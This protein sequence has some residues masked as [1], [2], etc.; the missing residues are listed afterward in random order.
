MNSTPTKVNGKRL[1]RTVL[2]T[3]LLAIPAY[4][5]LL[6]VIFSNAA[7]RSQLL[8]F[9]PSD[10]ALSAA[11][12]WQDEPHTCGLLSLR[13]IYRA[14]NLNPELHELRLR[15]GVDR[16]TVFKMKSTE[17][18]LHADICRVLAQD[19]FK[20]ELLELDSTNSLTL[21]NEHMAKTWKALALIRRS[22]NGN[23]HW[24]VLQDSS[25]EQI[26]VVDSLFNE[27]Y[28]ANVNQFLEH[29]AVSVF[30]VTPMKTSTK[31]DIKDAHRLGVH[32]MKSSLER[33]KQLEAAKKI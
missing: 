2:I 19:G 9:S 31:Q 13:S 16:A 1:L 25:P 15:L 22:E 4:F 33:I 21:L 29:N 5:I 28:Q 23:L 27:P 12:E 3:V 6:D 18:T 20:S 8:G 10:V 26:E 32:A 14:H 11:P 24:V 17:G 30:L 7:P